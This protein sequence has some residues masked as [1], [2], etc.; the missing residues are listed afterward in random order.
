MMLAGSGVAEGEA[1]LVGVLVRVRLGVIVGDG[2][3]VG[4]ELGE[5]VAVAVSVPIA[6]GV[7]EGMV[8]CVGVSVGSAEMRVSSQS[9]PT[10]PL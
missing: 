9:Y 10:I 2:V 3:R 1:V 4:V 8:V 7:A 6:V 5:A